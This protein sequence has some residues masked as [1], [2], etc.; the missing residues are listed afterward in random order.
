MAHWW[1]GGYS[2]DMTGTIP[3]ILSMRST[4]AGALE[5]VS[6]AVETA[7]PSFLLQRADHVYAVGEGTGTVT[8]FRRAG[9]HRLVADGSAPSGGT[10]PCNLAFTPEGIARTS[11]SLPRLPMS[12]TLL[13]DAILL[14][15][16]SPEGSGGTVWNTVDHGADYL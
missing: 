10:W 13:R 9:E 6:T 14:S 12:M 8:S 1:V 16:F 7:S 5:L 4:D 3:G 15:F 2:E 11:G